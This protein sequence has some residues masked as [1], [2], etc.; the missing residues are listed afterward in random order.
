MTRIKICGLTNR[1]DAL[2]A[3]EAGADALGLVFADSPRRVTPAAAERIVAGLPPLVS[4][5]GV[6]RNHRVEEIRSIVRR[7]GLDR[8][9][10]HGD[11][12]P[13]DCERLAPKVIKRFDILENDTSETLRERMERYR[14]SAYLLDPGAGSGR[15]FDWSLARDLPGPLIVSGGLTPENVG[16]AIRTLR[17]YAV[18]VSSGV[19]H[20]PG[21]KDAEKVKAFIRAVRMADAERSDA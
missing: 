20:E 16:E 8:V 3:V 5:I 10:L 14:V 17:P 1:E 21:R 19:E 2:L 12:S 11:E 18:D 13:D 7:V 4:V 9:Q 6:F 15:K